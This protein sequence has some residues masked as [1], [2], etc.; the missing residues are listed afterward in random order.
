MA[1]AES[2]CVTAAADL[3]SKTSCRNAEKFAKML[4]DM[5][6]KVEGSEDKEELS[7]ADI[8]NDVQM[9][10]NKCA[11]KFKRTSAVSLRKVDSYF[12][13]KHC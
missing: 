1:R 4:D 13:C 12:T 9:Q 8:N 2:T 5:M 7:A 6:R 10:I 11:F 3:S